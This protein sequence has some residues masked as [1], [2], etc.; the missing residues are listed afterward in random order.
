MV[1]IPTFPPV[2]IVNFA[3]DIVAEVLSAPRSFAKCSLPTPKVPV[4]SKKIPP[5]ALKSESDSPPSALSN[6]PAVCPAVS[7]APEI[8]IP[9]EAPAACSI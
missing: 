8:K 2:S 7:E 3:S 9:S 6:I 1:P 4:L 5:L